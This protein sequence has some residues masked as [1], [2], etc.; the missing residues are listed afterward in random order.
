MPV[1]TS[2]NL[3]SKIYVNLK[4]FRKELFYLVVM[5]S[6]LNCKKKIVQLKSISTVM[7]NNLSC[8]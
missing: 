8:T 6:N 7:S 3:A 2:C 1:V 5:N 4:A